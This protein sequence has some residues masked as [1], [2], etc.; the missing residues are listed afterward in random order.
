MVDKNI[1]PHRK[2]GT[3]EVHDDSFTLVMESKEPQ[4]EK[5]LSTWRHHKEHEGGSSK[6]SWSTPAKPPP[7]LLWCE[8]PPPV[9]ISQIEEI[10]STSLESEDSSSG[11]DDDQ[12][13]I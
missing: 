3:D 4:V 1:N 7:H 6:L 12:N 2:I 9:K 8:Q 5:P 13:F 10:G 11:H